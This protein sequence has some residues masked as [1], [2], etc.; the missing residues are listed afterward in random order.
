M[1]QPGI[2][3]LPLVLGYFILATITAFLI[4]RKARPK[5]SA[6][7][8]AVMG[9][10]GAVTAIADHV[11]GDSIFLPAG[12]YPIVNPPVWLRIVF[13]FLTVGV[14]RKVGSGMFTMAVFDI[15]GDILHFGFTGEPLWLIEDILTYGLLTDVAIFLT[16]GKIFGHGTRGTVLT[17]FEGAILG[18]AFSFVHPFLTY[19]FLAPL[20]FGFV[21]DQARVL[22]LLVTYIPGD[23]FVGG[24]SALLANRVSRVVT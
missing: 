9:V 8:L 23:V 14:V 2:T 18:F 24:I 1:I 19:G 6:V 7:D 20:I 22:Y 11:L 21:P 17:V 4:L 16:K 5:F 13:F 10:G 15:V 12:I 3:P